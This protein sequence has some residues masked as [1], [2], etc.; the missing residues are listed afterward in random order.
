V[1]IARV[2]GQTATSSGAGAGTTYSVTF[3]GAVGSGNAVCGV[4]S[5]D[6]VG[7]TN[8]NSVTDNQG[9]TYNLESLVVVTADNQR[10]QAF[11]RTNIVN[12]PTVVT[13]NFSASVAYRAM[14]ADEF[15]GTSTGSSDERDGAAHGGQYQAS[16]GTGTDA[17]SSGT[18]TTSTNGDLIY[19]TSMALNNATVGTGFT[20]GGAISVTDYA[21][22]TE[23][24]EQTTAG[25]GTAATFTQGTA[26]ARGTHMIAIKPVSG[27]GGGFTGTL[28][29]TE[30]AD[31]GSFTGNI[32]SATGTL[33]ATEAADTASFAG[34]ARW[35]MTLAATEAADTASFT[36]TARWN[37]V[38]AATEAADTAAFTGTAAWLMVL[39][40]TEA[41]DT[42]AFTGFTQASG[43]LA[44]TEGL[45]VAAFSGSIALPGISGVLTASESRDIAQILAT[46]RG[47]APGVLTFGRRATINRW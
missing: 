12:A 27:G 9:N 22:Q 30:S 15:S 6:D 44:A 25:S 32:G 45:D 34:T 40:A 46:T 41:A 17:V 5:W 29:A 3:S 39:A 11:S 8:L 10:T 18:F 16:A 24:R 4:V 38:L 14:V 37:A 7:G 42:A 36:G 28:A 19:G 23:W 21:L 2:Q 47:D 1:A 20:L 33:A 31:T 35:N 13:A 43:T 26:D